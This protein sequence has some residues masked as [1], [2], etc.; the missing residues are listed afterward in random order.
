[1]RIVL[2]VAVLGVGAI[3]TMILYLHSLFSQPL[4]TVKPVT[5]VVGSELTLANASLMLYNSSADFADYALLRYDLANATEA[6]LSIATYSRN[7]D[8]RI[9]LVNTQIGV[10]NYCEQCFSGQDL[11]ASLQ[12]YLQLYGLIQNGTSLDYINIQNLSEIP[13]NSIIILA[14]GLMP[15]GL[16]P[17]SFA[18]GQPIEKNNFTILNLL[19]RGDSLIY[20]G[21]NF[22]TEI[23]A[24]QEVFVTPQEAIN[25]MTA[26]GI[27]ALGV[28]TGENLT[29]RQKM[30]F[31]TPTFKFLGGVRFGNVSSINYANGTIV[32][33]SNYPT[34]AWG[35]SDELASDIAV[36]IN[37]RFWLDRLAYSNYSYAVEANSTDPDAIGTL[38]LLTLTKT[39]ANTGNAS[40]V[41]DN[42]Y[43][44]VTLDAYDRNDNTSVQELLPF[45]VRDTDLGSV[46]MASVFGEDQTLPIGI[47]VSNL[48]NKQIAFHIE[49]ENE[50]QVL[51]A[52]LPVGFYN[53]SYNIDYYYAFKM[54]PGYYFA[55]LQDIS[56]KRYATAVFYLAPVNI[57]PVLLDFKN[58]SFAFRLGSNNALISDQ[59]YTVTLNGG[60]PQNG[61]LVNGAVVYTLPAHTVINYGAQN[62][63]FEMFGQ[64]FT[65]SYQYQQ[66][67]SQGAIPS[68]YYEF[69]IAGVVV[70]LLNLILKAPVIDEY[71]ID[72]P[73]FPPSTKV[74]LRTD[75][76]TLLN[77]F[78][79][80]NYY[81]H[82]RYMPLTAEEVKT[83]V[84]GNIRFDNVPISITMQNMTSVL[85]VMINEGEVVSAAGYYA[86]KRWID[87]SKHDIEYLA[88]FRKI[89]DFCVA[90]A[91]L[92][93]ELDTDQ[94]VDMTITKKGNQ[95]QIIIYSN[96]SGM[97]DI[98]LG[99][100]YKLFVVFVDETTRLNFMDNLYSAYG[101]KAELLRVAVEYSYV[102]LLDASNLDQLIF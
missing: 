48:S 2:I 61:T 27:V 67:N 38:P 21:K 23:G 41:I 87:L 71:Y 94:H 31:N 44:V 39:I 18:G 92:F 102:I 5:G 78:D 76:G 49:I 90:N 99:S 6:N 58:A 30:Y 22:T 75:P 19:E 25:T 15:V 10:V 8:P 56:D 54:Q 81:Y 28:L 3:A 24:G 101:E 12:K 60:Y 89:R 68:Y 57:T 29:P 77:I 100:P 59:K 64:N 17:Y 37:S 45:R 74:K 85:N 26:D 47:E 11:L 9:Y 83:G 62:F 80:V 50:S 46:S 13:D 95:A 70:I 91:M 72:V 36:T 20:V 69:G 84:N 34:A 33:L 86:P 96:L 73:N 7:P 1:M 51:V 52:D 79:T 82:W 63:E 98:A 43:S 4:F 32:S 16:L 35:D 40:S 42:S 55:T 88:I 14:S 93:T 53:N 97:K 65:Y 66:A